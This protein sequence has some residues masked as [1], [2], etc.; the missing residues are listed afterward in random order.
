MT[1][2]NIRISRNL[3]K[4]E[5]AKAMD[6]TTSTYSKYANEINPKIKMA[7]FVKMADKI[8]LTNEEML[9]LFTQTNTK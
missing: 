2:E 7:N 9:S 8:N 5:M 3:T 4:G 6:M 1:L